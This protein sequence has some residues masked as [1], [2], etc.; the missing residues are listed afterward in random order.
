MRCRSSS[1]LQAASIKQPG[2]MQCM[3][4]FA[5]RQ[6]PCI[7][8]RFGWGYYFA[9]CSL[10]GSARDLCDTFIHACG[11]C[12]A[13]RFMLLP[14]GGH[15]PCICNRL[16]MAPNCII[17]PVVFGRTWM[18]LSNAAALGVRCLPDAQLHFASPCFKV[19]VPYLF[20]YEGTED[21][22]RQV[23]LCLA[24]GARVCAALSI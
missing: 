19:L 14:S 21:F 5:A 15:P 16:R 7:K 10:L 9:D 24:G 18:F 6:Q 4:T 12:S 11:K 1:A 23:Q 2:V 8:K 3:G 17:L 13:S 22:L 20:C